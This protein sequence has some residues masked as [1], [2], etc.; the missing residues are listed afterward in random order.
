MH[1]FSLRHSRSEL[2]SAL[3][4]LTKMFILLFFFSC[5]SKGNNTFRFHRYNT[6]EG[7]IICLV[8]KIVVHKFVYFV[9]FDY[10][11]PRKYK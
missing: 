6:I 11:C 9:F 5:I 4:G 7:V 2:H 8:H 1:L 3:L 10:L